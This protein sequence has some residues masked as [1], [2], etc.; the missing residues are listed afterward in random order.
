[1]KKIIILISAIMLSSCT[2][3]Y[4]QGSKSTAMDVVDS[5][6]NKDS[7][8]PEEIS[9]VPF[10]FDGEII[11]SRS[12]V[13]RIW[14][15]LIEAGFTLVDP[16]V[17]SVSPVISEDYVLFR[18]SWEM[19]VFFNNRIPKNTYKIAVDGVNGEVLM[20]VNREK[21]KTYNIMGLKAA[22]K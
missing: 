7:S 4:M 6:N 5:L 13:S 14:N 8:Q 22:A 11:V 2:S 15:G 18:S 12:S 19:E 9:T 20:L 16:T 17:T 1:M 3:L 10:L 21:Y